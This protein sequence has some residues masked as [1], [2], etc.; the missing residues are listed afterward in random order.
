MADTAMAFFVLKIFFAGPWTAFAWVFPMVSAE[1]AVPVHRQKRTQEQK[2]GKKEWFW[3]RKKR[4][5]C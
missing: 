5:S 4:E 3:M 1:T 2:G